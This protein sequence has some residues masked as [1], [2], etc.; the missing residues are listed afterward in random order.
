[1]ELI[2]IIV[3]SLKQI[4]EED[5]KEKQPLFLKTSDS[6]IMKF[7]RQVVQENSKS[8]LIGIAGESASGKTTFVDN[9]SIIVI[10]EK[11]KRTVNKIF[12]VLNL[13]AIVAEIMAPKSSPIPEKV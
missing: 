10:I 4:I 11:L 13:L 2:T 9:A 5:K 6:F 7:A 8:F 1:M 12:L 3:D